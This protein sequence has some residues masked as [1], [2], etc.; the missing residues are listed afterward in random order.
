MA[1]AACSVGLLVYTYAVLISVVHLFD[2]SRGLISIAR[3]SRLIK[4]G[5]IW[6]IFGLP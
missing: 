5:P 2:R 1:E 4:A 6:L 3:L